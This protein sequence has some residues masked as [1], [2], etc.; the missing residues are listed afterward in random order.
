MKYAGYKLFGL[1]VFYVESSCFV[2][3]SKE[4]SNR[5]TLPP[6]HFPRHIA[7]DLGNKCCARLALCDFR[8]KVVPVGK[9]SLWGV[10]AMERDDEL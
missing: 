5:F 2:T 6:L 3:R 7:D 9:E 10:N 1:P 8:R 4:V